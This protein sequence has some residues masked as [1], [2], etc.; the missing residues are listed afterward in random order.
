MFWTFI[1]KSV[2]SL[3]SSFL[4]VAKPILSLT[5]HILLQ[6]WAVTHQLRH[7]NLD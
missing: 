3:L 4:E 6:L 2:G 7:T 5:T 1:F